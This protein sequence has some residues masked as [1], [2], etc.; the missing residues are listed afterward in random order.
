MD[1]LLC[2]ALPSA[3][4][5][6]ELSSWVV[7]GG[8]QGKLPTGLLSAPWSMPV[9]VLLGLQRAGGLLRGNF[10]KLAPFAWRCPAGSS[11]RR[12]CGPLALEWG[13]AGSHFVLGRCVQQTVL[14]RDSGQVLS[15]IDW[16]ICL[17]PSPMSIDPYLCCLEPIF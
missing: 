9:G 11:W 10:G 5:L 13:S 16:D 12:D 1:T 15:H 3:T 7:A 4:A 8:W 2:W 17:G 14:K 6:C